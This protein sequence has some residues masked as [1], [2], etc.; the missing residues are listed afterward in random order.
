MRVR[1]GEWDVNSDSEFYT[2][3]ESDVNGVY[4]NPDFYSGNLINDIAIVR[5]VVPVDY[6]KK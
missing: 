4:V 2:H 3:Y 6:L 5:M 1:L